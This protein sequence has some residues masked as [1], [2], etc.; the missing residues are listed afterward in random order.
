MNLLKGI[1]KWGWCLSKSTTSW[2]NCF[3]LSISSWVRS[4][5]QTNKHKS[6]PSSTHLCLI[7]LVLCTDYIYLCLLNTHNLKQTLRSLCRWFLNSFKH[8][9][10]GS[11]AIMCTMKYTYTQIH[12]HVA[13]SYKLEIEIISLATH[14][15]LP[16]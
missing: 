7:L 3:V 16:P 4:L 8:K 15:C 1:R 9:T 13:S 10:P 12:I 14:P 2:E 5:K 6:Q 11:Q